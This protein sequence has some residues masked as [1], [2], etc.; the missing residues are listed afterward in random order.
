M[1]MLPLLRMSQR[2][3]SRLQ[4]L[5][6]RPERFTDDDL[7]DVVLTRD[8]KQRFADVGTG[9]GNYFRAELTRQ[10]EIASQPMFVLPAKA[11]AAARCLRR[12]RTLPSMPRAAGYNESISPSKDSR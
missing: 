12:S 7:S 3:G 8:S 9:R 5:P 6:P 11:A 10:R 1:S 2:N 4:K